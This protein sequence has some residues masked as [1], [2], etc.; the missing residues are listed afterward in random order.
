MS[1]SIIL[2]F[3]ADADYLFTLSVRF[4]PLSFDADADADYVLALLHFFRLAG[5]VSD[6]RTRIILKM[7]LMTFGIGLRSLNTDIKY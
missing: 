7:M 2:S 6:H 1:V 4:C 3:D 5:P